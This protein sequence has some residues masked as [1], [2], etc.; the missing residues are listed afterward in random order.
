LIIG[1][2]DQKLINPYFITWH[3]AVSFCLYITS[4]K[5]E[6]CSVLLIV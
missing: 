6:N 4:G 2:D 3:K 1:S 5:K